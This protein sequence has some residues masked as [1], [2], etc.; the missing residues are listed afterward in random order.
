[1]DPV[2]NR[3]SKAETARYAWRTSVE[4][5]IVSLQQSVEKQSV[6][7]SKVNEKVTVLTA[8]TEPLVDAMLT[9][10]SGI[11]VIGT[12]GRV[13]GKVARAGVLVLGCWVFLKIFS[14]GGG[15]AAAADAMWKIIK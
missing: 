13:G 2:D 4:Q 5:A 7:I 12:V 8:K 3:E 1:M 9:M 6:C 15:L 11:R 14:S 10:Q